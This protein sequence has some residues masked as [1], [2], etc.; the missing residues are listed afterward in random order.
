MAHS[1]IGLVVEFVVAID[2]ARGSGN[3][4]SQ[5]AYS[6]PIGSSIIGLVVEFVVAIDEARVRFTDDAQFFLFAL[7][8]FVG[9]TCPTP[10]V[11]SIIGLVVEFVVAIDEARVRFTD[12][13]QPFFLCFCIVN[14]FLS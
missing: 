12:D 9:S 6:T 1:I 13:A 4:N 2:E 3:I 10:L 5:S 14:T 11:P 8:H 7:C